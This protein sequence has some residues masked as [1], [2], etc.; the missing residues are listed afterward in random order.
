MD[1]KLLHDLQEIQDTLNKA[2][3][4]S[5]KK[6]AGKP[7]ADSMINLADKLAY[8][9]AYKQCVNLLQNSANASNKEDRSIEAFKDLYGIY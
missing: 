5:R 1:S 2:L 8:Q 4:E 3:S 9:T 7:N 6:A